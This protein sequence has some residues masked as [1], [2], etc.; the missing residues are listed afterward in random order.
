ML[1][2]WI[3]DRDT[4][5]HAFNLFNISRREQ[6]ESFLCECFFL[7]W[8][9]ILFEQFHKNESLNGNY[10]LFIFTAFLS[11]RDPAINSIISA[12]WN[13][14]TNNRLSK[15]HPGNNNNNYYNFQQR[16]SQIV[17]QT[18]RF[19]HYSPLFLFEQK[20][21]DKTNINRMKL[22]EAKK[23]GARRYFYYIISRF[24][25]NRTLR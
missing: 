24:Q 14:I 4:F 11:K 15:L 21:C 23:K 7:N 22:L 19:S 3:I 25:L 12:T 2:L 8:R 9:G 17:K 18:R 16:C 1:S 10:F 6:I 20:T 5:C 13:L